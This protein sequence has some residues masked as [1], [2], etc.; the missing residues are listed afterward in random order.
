M[1]GPHFYTVAVTS[2]NEFAKDIDAYRKACEAI[3]APIDEVL[4]GEIEDR[5]YEGLGSTLTIPS[6]TREIVDYDVIVINVSDI[7]DGI[8]KIAVVVSY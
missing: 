4:I 7:P 6:E 8:E 3:G 2:E 5:Y 1:S